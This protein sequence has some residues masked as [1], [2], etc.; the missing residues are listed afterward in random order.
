MVSEHPW[1]IF[2]L[3]NELDR[4]FQESLAMR[5]IFG[6]K[7]PINKFNKQTSFY[8]QNHELLNQFED[9]GFYIMFDDSRICRTSKNNF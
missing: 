6:F 7:D 5:D 1:T 3:A 4:S 9:S 2:N 8:I